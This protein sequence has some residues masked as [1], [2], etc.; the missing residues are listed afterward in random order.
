M[1]LADRVRG[2]LRKDKVKLW[3]PPYTPE[4]SVAGIPGEVRALAATYAVSLEVEAPAVEAALEELRQHAI[5]KLKVKTRVSLQGKVLGSSAALAKGSELT[6][7]FEVADKGVTVRT[8]LCR[9]L[10]VLRLKVLAGGRALVDEQSLGEQGW[11]SDQERE[12]KPLRVLLLCS[13]TAP[14]VQAMAEPAAAPAEPTKEAAA[15]VPASASTAAPEVEPAAADQC[16]V[17]TIREAAEKLTAEGFGDFELSDA[18]TGRLV[19]IP[20]AARQALIT[21]IALHARGRELLSGGLSGGEGPAA[22]PAAALEFLSEAD[23]CFERCRAAGAGQLL[24]QLENFGQLQLDICWAYAL[25]GDSDRLPDAE[26]RLYVAE[27]MIRRQVDSNFLTL[28]EVKAE[29][30]QT[31]PPEVLPSVRL[32]LLRGVARRY[33]GNMVGAKE[34]LMRAA[35]FLQSLKV[36]NGAVDAL[37]ALGATRQQAVAALRRCGGHADNAG[38]ELLAAAPRREAAQRERNE[39]RRLGQTQDGSFVDPDLVQQLTG[40]GL[41]R[42]AAVEALK[43]TNNDLAAALDAAQA[44]QQKAAGDAPVDELALAQLISMGFDQEKSEAALRAVGSGGV[45][46]AILKLTSME[47]EEAPSAAAEADKEEG[48]TGGKRSAEADA[49]AEAATRRKL[50]QEEADRDVAKRKAEQEQALD[51]A[52]EVVERELGRCLRR[53]DLEDDIAGAWLEDEEALVQQH[54]SGL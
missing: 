35:L 8:A 52:R 4:G 19:P 11:A 22:G 25:L 43:K 41:D 7:E 17:Q 30:G 28:A 45:E 3:E 16:P 24:E 54:L 31:L 38:A 5:A 37:L 44:E 29:Q 9:Q 32:W 12:N 21:A 27:R 33:R 39:Q 51:E 6:A 34:D 26:A 10:G 40:M 53:G 2:E 20:P 50:A 36:D 18:N 49:D 46:A 23:A 48:G 42:K 14:E 15:D 13:G 47:V 1:S